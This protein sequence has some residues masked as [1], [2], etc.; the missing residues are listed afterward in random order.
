MAIDWVGAG[1][2]GGDRRLGRHLAVGE[3]IAGHDMLQ[4]HESDGVALLGARD[5]GG[6]RAHQARQPR[7]ALLRAARADDSR[8]VGEAAAQHARERQ[9]AAMRGVDGAHDL[10]ERAALRGNAKPFAS[11]FD[12]G[13]LMA[14]RLETAG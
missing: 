8:A 6:H 13:R 4:T 2:G 14:Q 1:G 12:A 9:F 11:L 3:A 5:L 7:D 10:R